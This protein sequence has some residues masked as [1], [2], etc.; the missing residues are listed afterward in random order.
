MKLMKKIG[1]LLFCLTLS[2]A[3]FLLA[4]HHSPALKEVDVWSTVANDI[5][6]LIIW[7]WLERN[8]RLRD[9]L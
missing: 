5:G 4:A 3:F 7:E 9:R 1:S 6:L 8:L 2:I